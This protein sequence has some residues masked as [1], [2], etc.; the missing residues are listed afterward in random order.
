M[1]RNILLA[2][3]LAT[4]HVAMAQ[5]EMF[6]PSSKPVEQNVVKYDSLTNV[7][8]IA[9][10][11]IKYDDYD[12]LI[13][14]TILCCSFFPSS[15][16]SK[17]H[18]Y[19]II[20]IEDN[21]YG[22]KCFKLEDTQTG[23]VVLEIIGN[24][25]TENS[26][27]VV[28]GYYEKIKSL[29][30]NQEYVYLGYKNI[31]LRN[32]CDEL[33]NLETD[34]VTRNIPL[35]T[36]WKCVGIQVKPF[37][38]ESAEGRGRCP[39]VLIFDNPIFGKHYCYLENSHGERNFGDYKTSS[40][41][42]VCGRFQLKSYYDRIKAEDS[43]ALAK[44]KSMLIKKY[45]SNKA[46]L[47]LDGYVEIGM[48]KEMCKESWGEP[49]QINKSTGSWGTHEQWVYGSSYLYFENGKLTSIQN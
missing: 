24:E 43:A 9:Y 42:Y 33:I 35:E 37:N 32:K 3:L 16:L 31:G 14:Q 17:G 22:N 1:I 25:S 23:E 13:G 49:I 40:M 48:T 30:L 15:N 28:V 12:Y 4:C 27:F 47:I 18:Y 26:K 46:K 38:Y 5:I 29:V 8:C 20:G 44:R 21:R 2:I 41:P 19:K 6:E 7:H 34:T 10:S 11:P 36:I 39:I 45:G